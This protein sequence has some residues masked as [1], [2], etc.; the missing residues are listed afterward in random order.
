M[1]K[2]SKKKYC[3]H[4][5]KQVK[6]YI[7]FKNAAFLFIPAVLSAL[8]LKPWFISIGLSGSLATGIMTGLL[9]LFSFR[10]KKIDE[11]IDSDL[12]NTI[13]SNNENSIKIYS[14]NGILIGTFFGGF[15]AAGYLISRNIKRLENNSKSILILI[16]GIIG[17]ICFFVIMYILPT[18]QWNIPKSAYYIPQVII[19]AIFLD[20][21][22]KK[23]ITSHIKNDGAL[24]S[25]W[26]AFGISLLCL[27][28]SLLTAII[29]MTIF[30]V[31]IDV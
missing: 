30:G 19:V 7:D 20:L 24:E 15:L 22:H 25:S 28:V 18:E 5:S 10:I 8:A 26:K 6:S 14:Q 12:V 21:F 16:S 2:W 4:C 11:E 27:L 3:P 9:I 13:T 29:F 17:T 31:D 1:N 23:D